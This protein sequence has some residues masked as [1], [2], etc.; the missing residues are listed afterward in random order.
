MDI[1]EYTYGHYAKIKSFPTH[2]KTASFK[3]YNAFQLV[4]GF[5]AFTLHSLVTHAHTY[6]HDN[7]VCVAPAQKRNGNTVK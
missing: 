3:S 5:L 7:P 4:F 6:T 2:S 1:H